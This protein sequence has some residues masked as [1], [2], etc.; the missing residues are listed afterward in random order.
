MIVRELFA[1]LGLDLD[2]GSFDRATAAV[3]G[4][5]AGLVGVGAAVGAASV[6]L[7]ALVKSTADAGTAV[8][9]TSTKF[10]LSREALQEWQHA[11]EMS[12]VGSDEFEHGLRHLALTAYNAASGSGEAV[13]AFRQLGVQFRDGSGKVRP[14][15]A[16]LGDL[17]GRF[18]AM[19][20]STKKTALAQHL[21]GR[22]GS[23]LLPLLS[24]SKEAVAGLKQEA[25]ELGLVLSDQVID[26]AKEFSRTAKL[27]T[28]ALRGLGYAIGG[29]LLKGAGALSE[30]FARWVIVNRQWI[31]SRVHAAVEVLRVAVSKLL[32]LA[33][34]WVELLVAVTTNGAVVKGVLLA[35]ALLLGGLLGQAIGS[36]AAA[37]ARLV[38]ALTALG[39]R[40]L[41]AAS[42]PVLIGLGWL[43]LAAL[44]A[45]VAED[46]YGFFNGKESL[47]GTLVEKA[48]EAWQHFRAWLS[49][50]LDAISADLKR[51]LSSTMDAV[52]A[53]WKVSFTRFR[54]WLAKTWFLGEDDGPEERAASGGT[55]TGQW[56]QLGYS[57]LRGPSTWQAEP[58]FT[59]GAASPNAS[60]SR[61]MSLRT[62]QVV[63]PV[64]IS[65]NASP[66]QSPD[67]IAF[68]VRTE[69]EDFHQTTLREAAAAAGVR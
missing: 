42:V 55:D 61:A 32:Q 64:N 33:R 65:V 3:A 29:P 51:V 8:A 41:I 39:I 17:N 44:I 48:K 21:F 28:A 25:H 60:A 57:L 18:A 50:T 4:L 9:K 47:T 24:K 45:L 46:I 16:L 13:H 69:I 67:D 2:Q 43:A 23:E 6:G 11:A 52:I 56:S 5:Q 36:A 27:S 7:A 59:G 19:E 14:L 1:R 37:V 40:G 10:G 62:T 30:A 53:L 20:G 49:T 35:L 38:A 58:L 34:P 15:A 26:D 31:A 63:S 54:Q 22:G 68:A 12:G 66:S